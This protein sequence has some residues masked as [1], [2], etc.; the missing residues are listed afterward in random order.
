MR[1][2]P[3]PDVFTLFR[4][5]RPDDVGLWAPAPASASADDGPTFWGFWAKV[6]DI[7][8]VR[9]SDRTLFRVLECGGVEVVRVVV[10]G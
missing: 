5:L 9:A 1:V 8:A 10:S 3:A 2:S 6:V 7:H 4:G